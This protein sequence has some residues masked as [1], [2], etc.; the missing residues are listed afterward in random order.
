MNKALSTYA[1]LGPFAWALDLD[2]KYMHAYALEF[3][4]KVYENVAAR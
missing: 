4:H 3:L 1:K 2:R